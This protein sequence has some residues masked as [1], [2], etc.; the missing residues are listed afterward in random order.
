MSSS[1]HVSPVARRYGRALFEAAHDGGSLNE[2]RADMQQLA[3]VFADADAASVLSDPRV[4][5]QRKG[6][7]LKSAFGGK[8]HAHSAAL[9]GV[10]ESRNRLALLPQIP[11]AFEGLL[12]QHEGRLRGVLETARPVDDAAKQRLEQALSTST[13][14]TVQLEANVQEDLLGGVRVTLAGTRFDGSARGRLEK[15]QLRLASVEL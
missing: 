2:V 12:D 8:L 11:A 5:Q 14:K 1:A 9:L 4:E 7:L 13:G 3:A 6:A 15:L 10:L